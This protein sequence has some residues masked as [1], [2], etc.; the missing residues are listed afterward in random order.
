MSLESNISPLLKFSTIFEK[1]MK[2]S[3]FTIDNVLKSNMFGWSVLSRGALGPGFNSESDL[4]VWQ[5]TKM[6]ITVIR[7]VKFN[8]VQHQLWT[9]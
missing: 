4:A 8:Q 5:F 1:S 6:S 9:H 2:L 3:S 7:D